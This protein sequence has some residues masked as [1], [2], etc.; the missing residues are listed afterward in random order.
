MSSEPAET[1]VGPVKVLSPASTS[2]PVPVFVRPWPAPP[3]PMA[4]ANVTVLV[5][6]LL[7]TRTSRVRVPAS[8]AGAVKVSVFSLVTLGNSVSAAIETALATVKTASV[9]LRID[10][11]ASVSGPVPK[12]PETTLPGSP[13]ELAPRMTARPEPS[14]VPPV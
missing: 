8:V 10:P 4:E 14:D 7:P 9:P 5:E 6:T 12:G 1:V 2:R 11:P 13:V 3:S